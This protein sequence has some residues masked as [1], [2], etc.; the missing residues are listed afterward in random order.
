MLT[1]ELV[2]SF[3]I[4]GCASAANIF[5]IFFNSYRSTLA[6][7][8][9]IVHKQLLTLEVRALERRHRVLFESIQRHENEKRVALM[10]RQREA[11]EKVRL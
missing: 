7:E 11:L 8:E 1:R 5:C 9:D 3:R 6:R 4:S 10:K 2:Q